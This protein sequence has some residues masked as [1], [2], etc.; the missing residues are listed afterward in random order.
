MKSN[1]QSNRPLRG[2]V[3]QITLLSVLLV[4]FGGRVRGTEHS[5]NEQLTTMSLQSEKVKGSADDANWLRKLESQVHLGASEREIAD[6]AQKL[7][8]RVDTDFYLTKYPFRDLLPY[9]NTAVVTEWK[10]GSLQL[11]GWPGILFI[12]FSDASKT[13]LIDA[14]WFK[15]GALTPLVDGLYNRNLHAVKK[16]DSVK[17]LYRIIGRRQCD[18]FLSSAGKW[19]VRFIYWA[20][21]GRVF[22]IEADASEGQVVY[23]GEGTL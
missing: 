6:E 7:L 12:V 20:Y 21:G 3:L 15:D 13:N 1:W 11:D 5:S 17:M 22:V 10:T 4:L 8:S 16:G 14:F 23:A 2:S 19:R 9:T 18:Y